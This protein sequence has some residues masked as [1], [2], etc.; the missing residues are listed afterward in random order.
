M[1]FIKPSI[2]V[3]S[4]LLLV[5]C[6]STAPILSTPIENIDLTPIKERTLTEKELQ[7]W[8]HK[9]LVT[10]TI[11]GMSVDKAYAE[12]IKGKKGKK[13]IVAVLDSGIDIDHEDLD[14][15]IWTNTKEIPNNGK[16]DDKNG[17]V[18][19]IHGWN[20][21]GDSYNE[22]LEITR[23]VKKGTSHPEYTK[24][25]AELDKKYAEKTAL[26]PQME[27]LLQQVNQVHEA[28]TKHFKKSNYTK[29]EV[30]TIKNPSEEL[31]QYIGA[32]KYF[33]SINPKNNTLEEF[34]KEL[35]NYIEEGITD[36]LNYHLNTN[37]NGRTPVG[38]NPYDIT[39]TNYG[40]GNV[41]HVKK[42][43]MHG[44]HVAGIIAAERNNGKGVNGVANNV[45]IMAVRMVP[46]GDEYDKDVALAIRYAVDNGAQIINA[47]FGKYYSPN[48]E[49]VRDAIA[50][51]GKNNVLIVKG[52]GNENTD[53]DTINVYPNDQINNGVEIADNF[54]SVGALDNK[55][56]SQMIADYSNYGKIN[57]D[58]FAPGSDIYSTSPENEYVAID[59]TSM[60]SPGVAGVAALVWSQYPKLTAAQVKQIIM[61]SG[62]PISRNV[63]IDQSKGAMQF[64][65]SSRSGK[66][67]NAYNALILAD[68]VSRGQVKL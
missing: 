36:Y 60:A 48:S 2:F 63:I 28:L 52:S 17:Y 58:I 46:N 43:E 8:G 7:V 13:I 19:D 41:K 42:S 59:G 25:K 14:D 23:I 54:I 57:V 10:D 40:N 22:N 31:A 34:S 4:L 50:Y 62:L 51:A 5:G 33:F 30:N 12:I 39:D 56:G 20:F 47:S 67:V 24:A 3:A 65:K 53:L 21:V 38:D 55:Y 68:K 11:P 9:D 26:K 66:I 32:A 27:S 61:Q 29:E 16:D 18:D 49:W 64:S 45:A 37:F 44:T 6:G 1:K 15:V 35:K